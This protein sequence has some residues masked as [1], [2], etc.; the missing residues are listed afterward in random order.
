MMDPMR[1]LAKIWEVVHTP[2]S[3]TAHRRAND[4]YAADFE[5]IRKIIKPF[6]DAGFL[7]PEEKE[8]E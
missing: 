6:V 8:G 3:Q 5:D 2:T 7:V 1:A 4:H